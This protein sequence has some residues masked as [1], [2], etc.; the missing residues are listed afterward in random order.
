MIYEGIVIVVQVY[1][2]GWNPE[3]LRLDI[4]TFLSLI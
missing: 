2:P 4:A 3:Y 1:Q